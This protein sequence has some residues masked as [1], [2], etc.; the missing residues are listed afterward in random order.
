VSVGIEMPAGGMAV[1]KTQRSWS[2]G[3]HRDRDAGWPDSCQQDAS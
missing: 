1:G 2:S 3:E